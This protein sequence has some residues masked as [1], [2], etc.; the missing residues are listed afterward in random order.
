MAARPTHQL[1]HVAIGNYWF[2]WLCQERGLERLATY[3]AL[4]IQ[5]SAPKLRAPFNI[6]ARLKAGFTEAEIEKLLG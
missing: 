1:G 6:E 5:Y 2:N 3:E 4:A